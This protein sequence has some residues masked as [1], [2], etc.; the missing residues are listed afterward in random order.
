MCEQKTKKDTYNYFIFDH[1][2]GFYCFAH[3]IS[4]KNVNMCIYSTRA[5]QKLD[6]VFVYNKKKWGGRGY[7]GV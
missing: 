6:Y 4:I 5:V 2:F 7:L 1:F 3:I